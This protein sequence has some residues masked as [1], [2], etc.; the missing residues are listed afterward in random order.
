[1]LFS[2][3]FV[4]QWWLNSMYCFDGFRVIFFY[5]SQLIPW[6]A[7]SAVRS[8]LAVFAWVYLLICDER[9][10]LIKEYINTGR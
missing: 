1:M 2:S 5:N 4:Q 9:N 6:V 3:G 8:T 10:V 7:L